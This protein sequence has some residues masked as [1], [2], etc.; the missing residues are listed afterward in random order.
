MVP[1]ADLRVRQRLLFLQ[2]FSALFVIQAVA[3]RLAVRTRDRQIH[4]GDHVGQNPFDR[5]GIGDHRVHRLGPRLIEKRDARPLRFSARCRFRHF[6]LPALPGSSPSI[7]PSVYR[8]RSARNKLANETCRRGLCGNHTC[9]GANLAGV[10]ALAC[11]F[12]GHG[13][14]GTLKR[15][16]QQG[17]T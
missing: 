6:A 3:H 4:L 5:D 17:P 8:I 13:P 10:H 7:S 14:P 9:Q 12:G 15:E 16:L 11:F 2:P 1:V